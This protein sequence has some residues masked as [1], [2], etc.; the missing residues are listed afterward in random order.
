MRRRDRLH[1]RS[2]VVSH[3][4]RLHTGRRVLLRLAANAAHTTPCP[5]TPPV[6]FSFRSRVRTIQLRR[7]TVRWGRPVLVGTNKRS[8]FHPATTKATAG[9]ASYPAAPS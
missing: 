2:V 9:E 5:E 8:A 7:R 6:Y 4:A 1:I 3:S